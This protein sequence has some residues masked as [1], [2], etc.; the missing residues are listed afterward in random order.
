MMK[1]LDNCMDGLEEMLLGKPKPPANDLDQSL[2]NNQHQ[3][4]QY[5][6]SAY[7]NQQPGGVNSQQPNP[8]QSNMHTSMPGNNPYPMLTPPPAS[9]PPQLNPPKPVMNNM[10]VS[11]AATPFCTQCGQMCK[12]DDAFCIMCGTPRGDAAA[13]GAP[14]A[15]NL[16]DMG[17]SN[18]NRGSLGT[19]SS[20]SSAQNNSFSSSANSSMKSD[21]PPSLD[22][23]GRS[24]V[25]NQSAQSINSQLDV[26]GRSNFG[27]QGRTDSNIAQLATTRPPPV[28]DSTEKYGGNDL[29]TS[30]PSNIFRDRMQQQQQQQLAAASGACAGGGTQYTPLQ[31]GQPMASAMANAGGTSYSPMQM[32]G[33]PSGSS[34]VG[35]ANQNIRK[36]SQANQS[37][38]YQSQSDQV[39]VDPSMVEFGVALV[40]NIHVCISRA[41]MVPEKK[42]KKKK[43]QRKSEEEEKE[44]EEEE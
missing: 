21:A 44:E 38:L 9:Q 33:S 24:G 17:R 43:Q 41:C 19:Q 18:A 29:Y 32:P 14:A 30:V 36:E 35:E 5:Q 40:R 28:H 11:S 13:A 26:S 3:N 1:C 39:M 6:M 27:Q 2:I 42:K 20:Y 16:G 25:L 4:N 7:P 31:Q 22:G 10:Y 37:K 12:M 34:S 15:Q 8:Y 23:S